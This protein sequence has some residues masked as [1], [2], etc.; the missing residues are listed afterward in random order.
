MEETTI[1]ILFLELFIIFGILI[2][3]FSF[4]IG[5]IMNLSIK[6]DDG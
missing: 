3:L 2:L 4:F 1:L 5:Y 6:N